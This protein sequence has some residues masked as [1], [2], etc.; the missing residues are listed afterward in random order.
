MNRAAVSLFDLTGAMLEPWRDAGYECYAYDIQHS[1]HEVRDGIHFIEAD[2]SRDQWALEVDLPAAEDLAIVFAFPPCDHLA[3]SGARWFKGKGLRLLAHSINLFAAAA[4]F[5]E[6]SGAPYMI[7]N[8]ISTISTY[9]READHHF[10]PRHYT[11]FE[12]TD[13]Y[14]KDTCLWVGAGFK[15]P[16]PEHDQTLGKP[17]DRIHKAPPGPGRAN[18][19][20]ATPRGFARAVFKWNHKQ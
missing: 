6:Q 4:E 12:L 9:W 8:P 17:D 20:S 11:K 3:V 13:N 19:R 15:F 1:G 18:Y 2:L 14:T 7:E 5:C 10:H 16:P